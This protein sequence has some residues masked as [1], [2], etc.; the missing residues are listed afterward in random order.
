MTA[1]RVRYSP[2]EIQRL[3]DAGLEISLSVHLVKRVFNG[4]I[5]EAWRR[6]PPA[7]VE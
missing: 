2:S 6:P 5:V 7:D 3:S 1:D 4:E